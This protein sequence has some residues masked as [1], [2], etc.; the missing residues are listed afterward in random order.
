M[1]IY[2][3]TYSVHSWSA[4]FTWPQGGRTRQI[5]HKQACK[6]FQGALQSVRDNNCSIGGCSINSSTS[7]FGSGD[8]SKLPRANSKQQATG[9]SKR[10]SSQCS[11]C[12]KQ[13]E[14]NKLFHRIGISSLLF[15]ALFRCP[16][17]LPT[18]PCLQCSSYSA[19]WVHSTCLIA[20]S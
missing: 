13:K 6:V 7:S 19:F 5:N 20:A 11:R 9:G 14:T 17:S 16:L 15:F 4:Q 8:S 12:R 3:A 18:Y 10:C 2:K 1:W